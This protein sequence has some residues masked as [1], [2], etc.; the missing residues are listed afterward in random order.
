MSQDDA[1]NTLRHELVKTPL[2]HLFGITMNVSKVGLGGELS[3]E[4]AQG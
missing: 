1:F 4:D 2:D 3:Q